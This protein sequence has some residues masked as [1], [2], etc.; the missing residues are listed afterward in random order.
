LGAADYFHN[1]VGIVWL[2]SAA[3]EKTVGGTRTATKGT[4]PL[5]FNAIIGVVK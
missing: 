1:R 2:V 4:I 5:D 3:T